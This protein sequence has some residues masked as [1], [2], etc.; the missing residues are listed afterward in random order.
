MITVVVFRVDAS[1]EIGTGHVMRC[2]TLADALRANG[3][4]CHFICREH[5]GSLIAHI[6]RKGYVVHVLPIQTY[7]TQATDA[8]TVAHAPWLGATQVED[9]EA[10]VPILSDLQPSWLIVD[11]YALDA[12][13]E[14]ILRSY[15]RKLMVID[16]L[17]D[18]LHQC[19][20]LLDQTHGRS[21]NDY[22]PWVPAECTLLCGAVYALLRPEFADWRAYSLERRQHSQLRQLLITMG[23][24]DKDNATGSV[25]SA[26]AGSPLPKDTS[27][28]V[29]L[30]ANAP[31][32]AEVKTQVQSMP[33]RVQVLMGVNNMARLMADSDLAIGAAGATTWERCSLGLPTIL[34]ILA[35]NQKYAA[36]LLSQ[37]GVLHVIDAEGDLMGELSAAISDVQ[38]EGA[39]RR[40]SEKS[41]AITDGKGC[42]R[43]LDKLLAGGI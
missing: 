26:L 33:W 5:S 32:A 17:A 35:E 30:G 10:C 29:V 22:E 9:A 21:S 1:L 3:A 4:E 19:D 2:L 14:T 8:C 16:D 18:R 28:I 6:Q 25:L 12:Q 23:G 15:Y 13:W 39:L 31:W 36:R 40:L 20:L 27:I 34:L 24:I 7:I 42:Y 41:S 11:H 38:C 37:E 43:V